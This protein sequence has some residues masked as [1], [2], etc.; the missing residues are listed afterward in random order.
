MTNENAGNAF[1]QLKPTCVSLLGTARLTPTN[2]P[3]VS[4]H[5]STLLDT[6]T[7]LTTAQGARLNAHLIEYVFFP[8]SSILQ[9]NDISTIPDQ[10][11]EKLFQ[12]LEVL[13]RQWWWDYSLKVWEQLVKICMSVIGGLENSG[14]SGKT[15]GKGK[16]KDRSEETKEAAA[17]CLD[18]LLRRPTD[19]QTAWSGNL[20][21]SAVRRYT[22]I[23]DYA[24]SPTRFPVIGQAIN[25]LLACANSELLSFKL[26]ILRTTTLLLHDYIPTTRAPQVLPG[27]V[28]TMCSVA[29]G[30]KVTRGWQTGDAVAAA[31]DVLSVVILNSIG[32]E[33][34]LSDGL[35]QDVPTG[36]EDLMDLVSPKA[37]P[38]PEKQENPASDPFAFRRTPSW[39]QA[40]ASQIHLAI[41]SLTPL[42]SHPTPSAQLALSTLSSRLLQRT[43]RT[44]SSLHPLL[45]SHLLSL[46]LSSFAQISHPSETA[47]VS[48]LTP[49]SPSSSSLLR[50]LLQLTQENLGALP[51]LILSHSDAKVELI[52]KQIEG[53]CNLARMPALHRTNITSGVERLLG[54]NGG[55]EKWGSRLLGVL[56]LSPPS[57]I[58]GINTHSSAGLLISGIEVSRTGDASFPHLDLKHVATPSAYTSLERMFQALGSVA[59]T[60]ALS[61]VEWLLDLAKS[62]RGTSHVSAIWTA[63]RILEGVGGVRLAYDSMDGRHTIKQLP[64]EEEGLRL[65]PAR[66]RV[67]K[68]ARSITKSIAEL[69]E[70][71]SEELEGMVTDPVLEDESADRSLTVLGDSLLPTEHRKGFNPLTTLVD[72]TNQSSGGLHRST[73]QEHQAYLRRQMATLHS[74]LALTTISV[75]ASILGSRFPPLLIHALYPIL[76]SLVSSHAILHSTALSALNH[77]AFVAGYASTSNLL[78]SNF[79]YALDSVSR[80][81]LRRRL[82]VKATKVLVLLVRLV[83]KDVVGRAGDVVEECFDRLDEFH[84]YGVIV[85]GLIAVLTEVVKAAEGEDDPTEKTAHHADP[86]LDKGS[87][88][89]SQFLNWY[90][91]RTDTAKEEAA[92]DFGPTPHEPWGHPKDPKD[93]EREKRPPPEED[94]DDAKPTP[95]Q[96][97]VSQIIQRSLPFLT[98]TSPTIRSNILSLMRSSVLVLP[99]NAIQPSVH[100]AWP[101]ILNRLRDNQPF[102]V[103]DAARLIGALA[104]HSGDFMSGRVWDDVWPA[105]RRMLDALVEGDRTN[106]LAKRSKG[107]G[108]TATQ[109]STS[110]RLYLA[111]LNTLKSVFDPAT[112]GV[113]IK[114]E[115]VWEVAVKC[116]R[117]LATSVHHEL[118]G[119]SRSL[120]RNLARRNDDLVWLVLTS[121]IGGDEGGVGDVVEAQV[122]NPYLLAF[123]QEENWDIRDSVE[124][125]LS[126]A[127]D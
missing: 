91:H 97:L 57:G 24:T 100:K 6:L 43:T 10:L 127:F 96:A 95:T 77:V 119:M 31:L 69:W 88:K 60:E 109:Y 76:R 65:T 16:G 35:L 38:E 13:C 98:H 15:W 25:S 23:L 102:V 116:R 27:V 86:K 26:L 106:A 70:L 108:G 68:A 99:P 112:Q 42:L 17:L 52:A 81:L 78:L 18:T 93:D 46:S 12:A 32:D 90:K 118:Q 84:G 50:T 75:C 71:N 7:G 30:R 101:F 28:S 103:A 67:E 92:E 19:E 41:N 123:L 48:L 89:F 58:G 117:F 47:L 80:R 9:R 121:T 74:T 105:Y 20:Q 107:V 53:I 115:L 94:A 87:Q 3:I 79:D 104:E 8:I 83:G 72:T 37:R 85:E 63:T 11:L 125:I 59:G 22:E 29:L 126:S 82:D 122:G 36:L 1:G 120:Y 21:G 56:E 2:T 14:S 114:D 45:L 4:K 124:Y 51:T 54:P 39:L 111:I 49:S 73:N 61:S 62:G 5:L 55:I 66:K 34:C 110:H 40:T 113:W 44:L 33:I 64:K